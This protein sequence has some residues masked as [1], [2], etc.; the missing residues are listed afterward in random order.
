[1]EISRR[2]SG[3][4]EP[5]LQRLTDG[6]QL[7]RLQRDLAQLPVP[8]PVAHYAARLILASHPEQEDAPEDVRRYVS[9]GASP[10][11]LQALIRGARVRAAVQG[12]TAVSCED[13]HAM[14]YPALRHRIILNFEGEARQ[15][16]VD[17]LIA[18]I[19]EQVQT[20]ARMAA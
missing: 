2:T 4:D 20:P 14:A 8:D 3:F 15:M 5:Q 1:V 12:G 9:Y 13:I 7:Q 19:L 11:G 10:R 17:A 16:K 18:Q 6:E